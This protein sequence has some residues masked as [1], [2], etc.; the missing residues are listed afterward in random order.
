MSYKV[1]LSIFLCNPFI[2]AECTRAL[3]PS[4]CPTSRQARNSAVDRSRPC[5]CMCTNALH[6]HVHVRVRCAYMCCHCWQSNM[7][8]CA[9]T[10]VNTEKAQVPLQAMMA[11]V[12]AFAGKDAERRPQS[13]LEVSKDILL[14]NVFGDSLS[15]MLRNCDDMLLLAINHNLNVRALRFATGVAHV[16]LRTVS[17]VV[18]RS[19]GPFLWQ[20]WRAGRQEPWDQPRL[21]FGG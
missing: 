5:M 7:F 14:H 3:L 9:C 1:T 12:S 13:L 11:R 4:G 16:D 19:S 18:S 2:A 15:L 10:C 8:A 6:V 20:R 17:A 21:L